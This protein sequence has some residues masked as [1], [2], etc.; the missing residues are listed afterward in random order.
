MTSAD[1]HILKLSYVLNNGK[2]VLRDEHF[3]R[4]SPVVQMAENYNM[5]SV[6]WEKLDGLIRNVR[7]V[8][9]EGWGYTGICAGI[10]L[11]ALVLALL[12]Y[13]KR[14]LECA[15]DLVAVKPLAPVASAMWVTLCSATEST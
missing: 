3:I 13:R 9:G 14:H 11:L 15:G 1:D 10:G 12:I 6:K 2:R 7:I 5:F 4:F 8:I